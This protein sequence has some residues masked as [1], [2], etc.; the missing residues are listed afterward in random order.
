MDLFFH[1]QFV[2]FPIS[3][4]I[5]GGIIYVMALVRDRVFFIKMGFI[6]HLA[7]LAGSIMSILT[8][9]SAEAKVVHTQDIHEV[10]ILHERLAYLSTWIFA[11]LAI[12][13]FLR[14]KRI[15]KLEM[16]LF[17]L[18]FWGANITLGFM[19]HKGGEMV[20]EK[21]AGV[22]PMEIELREHFQQEQNDA[23]KP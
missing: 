19:A 8:G 13:M 12:W 16:A 4:L 21:G 1:P 18:L 9:R 10:L 15:A 11:M 20:Y 23:Y 7:G 2:H 14:Q 17:L 5:M 6:L 3:L 22:I